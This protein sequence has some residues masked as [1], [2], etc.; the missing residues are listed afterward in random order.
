MAVDG[1]LAVGGILSFV[2]GISGLI[3]IRNQKLEVI[4]NKR[5]A[6]QILCWMFICKGVANSLYSVGYDTAF[7]LI[8]VYGGHFANV[9]FSGLLVLVSLIFPV[10][11]L[12]TRKQ[13]KFGIGAVLA[14]IA[15]SIGV[16]VFVDI[17]SPLAS[18]AGMYF[19]PGFIWTLVYLKFRFM[20][21]QE[22]NHETHGV[23]DVA[24]LMVI[25]MIGHILFSWVGMFT[26]SELLLLHGP[27]WRELSQRLPLVSGPRHGR[28][29]RAGDP[30]W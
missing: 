4:W 21:G 26:A 28:H 13:F 23:A 27:L 10:P 2:L 12:R 8:V 29:L 14:Y 24:I 15:I 6:A 7:T 5:F 20:K 1:L 11:V 30:L 17:N 16:V 25:L 19:I 3:L 9:V 22:N 18:F